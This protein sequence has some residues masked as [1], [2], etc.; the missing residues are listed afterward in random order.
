MIDLLRMIRSFFHSEVLCHTHKKET[1]QAFIGHEKD[2]QPSRRAEMK[3]S[4][5]AVKFHSL[6]ILIIGD[7]KFDVIEHFDPIDSHQLS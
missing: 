6:H 4:P 5:T 7:A 3:H 1:N 2:T